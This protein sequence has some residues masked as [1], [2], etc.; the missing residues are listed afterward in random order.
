MQAQEPAP[1]LGFNRHGIHGD[2]SRAEQTIGMALFL[3]TVVN[4]VDRKGR[5][6]V[7]APFRAA[8]AGEAFQGIVA[9]PSFKYAA[10]QCGGMAWME[11]LSAGVNAFDLFSDDHDALSATLFARAHSLTFD[12][13]GRIGL[14]EELAQHAGITDAAAFVGRGPLF[15]IWEPT[16]FAAYQGEAAGRVAERGLT[17]KPPQGAG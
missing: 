1:S 14:P 8:L 10:L 2:N 16:A 12:G 3:S 11:Q 6:S 9:F 15:E 17:L 4:K 13:E 5:I 7:P